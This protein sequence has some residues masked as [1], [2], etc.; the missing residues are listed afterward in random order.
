[1]EAILTILRQVRDPRD[2]NARHD[3][4][5]ILFLALAATL[6]GAK[7]CVDM[8]DF[9]EANAEMLVEIVP[10]PHG[11]PSH[12]CFSRVFR[13]LDPAELEA[14][15]QRFGQALRQA[16]GLG[17]PKGVVAVDGKSLRGG[18]E[19]GRAC[20]A[21]LMVSVWD[22]ETRLSIAGLR[23]ENGDE[24]GATL[25]VLKALTLKGCTLTADA[26]YCHPKMAK[27]VR[28][29]GAHYALGLKGNHGP[30]HKAAL[31]AFAK[32]DAGGALAFHEVSNSGHD[33]GERRRASVIAKPA[34]APDFPGLAALG[35]IQ[36]ERT[37]AHGK[38]STDTRYVA[39]SKKLSPKALM[40]V[41][42]AH[43]SVENH[44]HWRLDVAFNEDQART[45][46]DN[47]PQNLAVIRRMALDILSSHPEKRSISRKMKLAAWK[48]TFF[49]ELFAYMQ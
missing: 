26:L 13:L 7:T 46:K 2:I 5:A 41:V 1:M 9:A 42:R 15:L 20:M 10:L 14:A 27:A 33:R 43:W 49:F 32:A 35:R 37:D 24:V 25:K 39:L 21:P 47:A 36:A 31:A 48:Q 28:D 44:L 16:L 29:S 34:A 4:S 11:T 6:C 19:R 8:A 12:D 22:A 18:Y 17:A 38:V 3:L 40:H 23:A 30:L 45:R